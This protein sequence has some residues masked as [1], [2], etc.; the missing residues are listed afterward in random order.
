MRVCVGERAYHYL[1]VKNMED[2]RLGTAVLHDIFIQRHDFAPV[3]GT[4]TDWVH[5]IR[6]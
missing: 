1:S 2:T 3:E 6:G 5:E 4:A